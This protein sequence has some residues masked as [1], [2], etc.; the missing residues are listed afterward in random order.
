ML[1]LELHARVTHIVVGAHP[2]VHGFTEQYNQQLYFAPHVT[3]PGLTFSMPVCSLL[4]D[5]SSCRAELAAWGTA[6]GT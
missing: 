3:M 6:A 5:E 4:S 1:D 2:V